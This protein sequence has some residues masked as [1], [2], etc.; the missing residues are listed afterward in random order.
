MHDQYDSKSVIDLNRS[1]IPLLEI[2]SEPN[3]K[4]ASEA[5]ELPKKK[6]IR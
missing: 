1:G 3:I 4:S 2:V 5:G 6:F